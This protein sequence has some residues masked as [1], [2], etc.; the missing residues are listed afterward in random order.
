[1]NG[2]R[3]VL[4]KTSHALQKTVPPLALVLPYKHLQYRRAAKRKHVTQDC[5]CFSLSLTSFSL[6]LEIDTLQRRGWG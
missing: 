2:E 3:Q 1:M 6:Y 5:L 4:S